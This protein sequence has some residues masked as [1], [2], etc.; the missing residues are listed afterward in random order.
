MDPE[1]EELADLGAEAVPDDLLDLG[2]EPAHVQEV[3]GKLVAQAEAIE[4]PVA[5]E[6]GL[7]LLGQGATLGWADELMAAGR[8]LGD[9]TYEQALEEE[10]AKLEQARAS[11]ASPWVAEMAGGSLLAA[12]PGGAAATPLRAIGTGAAVGAAAGAGE[13]EGGL[14]Q[15]VGGALTGGAVGA[16]MGTLGVG[17]G[18]GMRAGA[19]RLTRAAAEKTAEQ[20]GAT[21]AQLHRIQ[22]R[23]GGTANLGEKMRELGLTGT[24]SRVATQAE[25]V[26]DATGQQIGQIYRT[27]NE[28]VEGAPVV[29]VEA[30][31]GKIRK[32]AS[33]YRGMPEAEKLTRVYDEYIEKL[34]PS[35]KITKGV[36]ESGAVTRDPLGIERKLK[37]RQVQ[38]P[39]PERQTGF[40]S[41]DVL[42]VEQQLPQDPLMNIPGSAGPAPISAARVRS[43]Y[44]ERDPLG[45]PIEGADPIKTI[46]RATERSR[47][48]SLDPL[49]L[50]KQ[51]GLETINRLHTRLKRLDAEIYA[52]KEIKT[53][54]RKEALKE[55]R[56]IYREEL[57]NAIAAVSP[58]LLPELKKANE[59]YSVAS[60]VAEQADL[61]TGRQ[62]GE[63]FFGVRNMLAASLG[64]AAG[65]LEYAAGAAIARPIAAKWGKTMGA[66]GLKGA[67]AAADTF[68]GTARRTA[69]GP[70]AAA[71][72][73]ATQDEGRIAGTT[74]TARAN[75]DRLGVAGFQLKRAAQKGNEEF[76][77]LHFSLMMS[78]PEYR[79]QIR[80]LEGKK[81]E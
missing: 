2:A 22:K 52:S 7:R 1:L 43:G 41:R 70:G 50:E 9:Q 44:V 62:R 64:G 19:R 15:R 81:D 13:A 77:S 36:V 40:V 78:D 51:K 45:L 57:D 47:S 10:R 61:A 46:R 21:P 79:E 35:K 63:N 32:L 16:G 17:L 25:Q 4:K 23:F 76:N 14:T 11:V 65:G 80:K 5:T 12:L 20:M 27:A 31:R 18:A 59:A 30:I 39:G 71:A 24:T 38:V 56:G 60:E 3:K 68:A 33:R 42:G 58:D 73:A 75:L 49:M 34:S 55:I 74:E 37:A 66:G 26:K 6:A 48:V 67:A 53:S 28:L 29:D 69:A 8:S 72:G 54:I